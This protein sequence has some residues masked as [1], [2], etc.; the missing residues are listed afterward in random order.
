MEIFQNVFEWYM[1]NLNYWTIF[2][3]MAIESSFI[4]FPSEIVVPFAAWKAA[5]G[6]LSLA[7]VMLASTAGAMVGAI[8]NYYFALW[9]GRPVLY[10]L[11]NTRWAHLLLIDRTNIEKAENYFVK[12]GKSSTFIGR[13]VPAVRQLI[14]LPA[15]LARMKIGT[16]LLYT[17]LGA[18]TWNII[19]TVIGYF[20]YDMRDH[21][22]PY[23]DWVMYAVGAL[24]VAWLAYQGVKAYRRNKR[25]AIQ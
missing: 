16:F 5:E 21:I 25:E 15:G 1:A 20:A 2:L 13:L 24:F 6:T 17:L 8:F 9:L 23:L 4:P 3:L 7:G 14:S 11:A 12:H 10:R 18:G 19:L 22:L